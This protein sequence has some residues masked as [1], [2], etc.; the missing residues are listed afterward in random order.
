MKTLLLAVAALFAVPA[1]AADHIVTV[2]FTDIAGMTTKS[3][4]RIDPSMFSFGPAV[5]GAEEDTS[6]ASSSGFGKSKEE[7]CKWALLSSFVKM[8]QKAKSMGKKVVG[9]RTYAGATEG[10][11]A[12]QLVCIAGA[13]IVRSTVKG[14][15]K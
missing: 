5:A 15:Y 14:G 11:K 12:D 8:Q 9:V 2:T 4:D 13:M 1:F 3:G 6:A 7:S 10:A